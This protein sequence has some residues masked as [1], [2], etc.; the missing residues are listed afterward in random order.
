[1]APPGFRRVQNGSARARFVA[2]PTVDPMAIPVRPG[3]D[4]LRFSDTWGVDRFSDAMTDEE[5]YSSILTERMREIMNGSPY[6]APAEEDGMGWQP[7]MQERPA[8]M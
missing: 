2:N 1:M 3:D 5:F 7:W 8:R 4:P 6:N